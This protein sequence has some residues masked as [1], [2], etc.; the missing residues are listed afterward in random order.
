M[1]ERWSDLHR[2]LHQQLLQQQDLL[3]DGEPLLLAV[4][5]GQDSMALVGLLNDLKRLHHWPLQL[6]HG[7]HGWRSEAEQQARE[8]QAWAQDQGL[9][10]QVDDW[11]SPKRDEASARDWRYGQLQTHAQRL[12]CRRV[13]TG[14]TASDRSE[15][16]LLQLASGNGARSAARLNWSAHCWGSPAVTPSRSAISWVCRFGWTP[17]TA[18]RA[19]VAIGS[20]TRCCL[21]LRPCTPEP[22]NASAN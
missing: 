21:S 1:A 8:L 11:E 15:T 4:S 9:P 16:V 6:W 20:A 3:P 18:T 12:G 5:G 10:I 14:H 13:V 7:N 22:A 17:A 19:S 2:R